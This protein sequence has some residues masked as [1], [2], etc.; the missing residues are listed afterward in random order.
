MEMKRECDEFD[1]VLWD[2]LHKL[3]RE[4]EQDG[5]VVEKGSNEGENI[6]RICEGERGRFLR[7][8]FSSTLLVNAN[9][10]Q[11][12]TDVSA[13]GKKVTL[14]LIDFSYGWLVKR[15]FFLPSLARERQKL[16]LKCSRRRFPRTA[17]LGFHLLR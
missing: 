17:K 6:L 9:I 12:P 13:D 2:R 16:F 14:W 5:K 10:K 3:E 11:W 1:T 7:V 4:W 8:D 15:K